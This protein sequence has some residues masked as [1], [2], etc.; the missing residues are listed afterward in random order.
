MLEIGSVKKNAPA[1][2]P[3]SHKYFS[4]KYRPFIKCLQRVKDHTWSFRYI[5]SFNTHENPKIKTAD[6]N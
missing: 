3:C 1:N 5:I 2:M 4:T 6:I